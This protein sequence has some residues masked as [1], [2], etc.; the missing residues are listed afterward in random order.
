[1]DIIHIGIVSLK[2]FQM[3]CVTSTQDQVLNIGK[4]YI[5]IYEYPLL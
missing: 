5:H 2:A 1:M 3:I 4:A